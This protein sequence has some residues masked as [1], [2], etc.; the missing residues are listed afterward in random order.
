MNLFPS[1]TDWQKVIQH[2]ERIEAVYEFAKEHLSNVIRRSGESYFTHGMEVANT[3]LESS[4][5][6][7]LIC[8][9]ILHDLLAHQYGETLMR[10]APLTEDE[11]HLIRQMYMLRRLHISDNTED[12]DQVLDAFLNDGRLLLLRMTHRLNDIRH[13]D[14]F[15]PELRLKIARE[16]LHMY[17]AIAGRLSMHAW[18]HEMEDRCFFI[19]YPDI[20]AHVKE[21]FDSVKDL[22]DVCLGQTSAFITDKLTEAGIEFELESR[23]KTYYSTYRKMVVKDRAFED[24]TDRLALRIIVDEVDMCYRILGIIHRSM[25]PMP[26]KLKDYIGAPKENGYQSIHTVV[27][28]LR[29]VNAEPIEIQIRTKEMHQLCEYGVASHETYK[30]SEYTLSTPTTRVNLLHNL[31]GLREGVNSPKQFSEAL[32]KYF[33]DD[34]IAVF[35][36][37][38]NLHHLKK[39]STA[40][41]FVERLYPDQRTRLYEIKVNGRRVQPEKELRDGDIIEAKFRA[42]GEI[43][44]KAIPLESQ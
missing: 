32:R 33:S 15:G 44:G 35:D 10:D 25:H 9:A 26:G 23:V 7:S 38:N 41:D 16:T 11:K 21:L 27:Y 2:H 14:R 43:T 3:L 4:K 34:Q 24:L 1:H 22:D 19:V 42:D 30:R 20:A 5:D 29:G 8:V 18:R 39:S 17:T 6:T 36:D 37:D 12:L 13:I 40:G 28:P 31:A